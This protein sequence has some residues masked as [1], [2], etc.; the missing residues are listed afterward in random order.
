MGIFKKVLKRSLIFL[1][2][3]GIVWSIVAAFRYTTFKETREYSLTELEGGVYAYYQVVVSDVPAHN[4]DIITVNANG[5]ILTLKGDVNIHHSEN[6]RLVWTAT[7][8]SYGDT[9][10]VYIPLD[11]VVYTS[12][13]YS[14]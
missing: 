8:V 4:Y 10:D 3:V 2:F 7:H 9:I 13:L 11:S 5:H 6:C 12:T 14:R 1:L